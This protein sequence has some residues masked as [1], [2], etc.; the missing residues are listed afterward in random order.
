MTRLRAFT[1]HLII[2][3]TIFLIFL[4]IM[5]LVWYPPPYFEIDGSWYV[6]RILAGV[7]VVI[8]PL[9][10]LILFKPGKPGLKFDM[11]CVALMQIGA[12]IYGGMIIYQ[13]HPAFVVFGVDRFTSIHRTKVEFAKLK[14]SELQRTTGIGPILAQALPPADPKLRQELMFAVVMEGQKDL[15]YRAE[16]YEPYQPD[17]AKLRSRSLDLDKLAALNDKAKEAIAAFAAQHGGRLQDYLYLPLRGKN[18]DIIMALSAVDGM[19]VGFI[20]I[21]PWIE[22]YPPKSQ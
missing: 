2:S 11:S 17:L 9:L 19:P 18:K 14:H 21:N 8:G 12:L 15:E 5:F 3:S 16:L 1:L 4:G 7:H 13:E 6:L 10:T 20:S 22:D